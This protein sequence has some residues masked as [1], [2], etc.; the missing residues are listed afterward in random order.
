MHNPPRLDNHCNSLLTTKERIKFCVTC[1][2]ILS[3]VFLVRVGDKFYY[4][5]EKLCT[6]ESSYV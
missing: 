6:T 3:G 4:G 5:L 2:P 1:V